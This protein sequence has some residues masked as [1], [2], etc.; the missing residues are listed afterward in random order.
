VDRIENFRLWRTYANKLAEIAEV[1][2]ASVQPAWTTYGT[3]QATVLAAQK[4]ELLA[5]GKLSAAA[6]EVLAFHGTT[7]KIARLIAESGFDFRSA[8]NGLYGLGTYLSTQS[9]KSHQYT[10]RG[11]PEEHTVILARVVLGRPYVTKSALGDTVRKPPDGHDSVIANPGQMAGHPNNHQE[12][13]ELV[14]FD[15]AQVFPCYVVRYTAPG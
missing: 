6:E 1:T 7:E 10:K 3:A 9:C 5:G 14:V 12:H 8:R 11:S 4:R 15:N 13:Q 2:P